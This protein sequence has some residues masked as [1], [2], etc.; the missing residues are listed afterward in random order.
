[1]SFLNFN[2]EMIQKRAENYAI[3]ENFLSTNI[4]PSAI[5]RHHTFIRL[6][7]TKNYYLEY[8]SLPEGTC[9]LRLKFFLLSVGVVPVTWWSM[10]WPVSISRPVCITL[11]W[12][13]PRA[14]GAPGHNSSSRMG[15]K[16]ISLWLSLRNLFGWKL[17]FY[18]SWS[19]FLNI[20]SLSSSSELAKND[21]LIG[22]VTIVPHLWNLW[23]TFLSFAEWI[24]V[25]VSE[26]TK[27]DYLV[28]I[29]V[30]IPPRHDDGDDRM[31]LRTGLI[32]SRCYSEW[33]RV[34]LPGPGPSLRSSRNWGFLTQ[35]SWLTLSRGSG[36]FP[37]P[38][39]SPLKLGVTLLLHA[40][41]FP[42][43]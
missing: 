7:I 29:W 14:P 3:W 2:K 24:R 9:R 25:S 12:A 15:G 33:L 23:N 42:D 39:L 18:F 35:S 37:A 4:Q 8:W 1:M 11:T 5:C 6:L 31:R 26:L 43:P 34:K 17:W 36:P 19:G 38:F 40:H 16:M 22:I 32:F 20:S 13:A 41:S 30:M 10:A 27:D 28:R 21:N